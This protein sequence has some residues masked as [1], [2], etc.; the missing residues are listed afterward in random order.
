M[1][2]IPPR[3]RRPNCSDWTYA[4]SRH[5]LLKW[6]L[7]IIPK[8]DQNVKSSYMWHPI[9]ETLPRFWERLF[10]QPLPNCSGL[11]YIQSE[12]WFS[13]ISVIQFSVIVCTQKIFFRQS[14]SRYIWPGQLSNEWLSALIFWCVFHWSSSL[15]LDPQVF[16]RVWLAGHPNTI[17]LSGL[18]ATTTVSFTQPF[19][20]KKVVSLSIKYFSVTFKKRWLKYMCFPITK[21]CHKSQSHHVPVLLG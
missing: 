16:Y 7:L 10:C 13:G 14:W 12:H 3:P 21:C 4:Q 5:F 11:T 15:Q 1:L 9:S 19:S 20:L 6:N 8:T 18:S 2:L 17:S